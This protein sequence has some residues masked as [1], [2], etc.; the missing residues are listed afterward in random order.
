MT[1]SKILGT[2]GFATLLSRALALAKVE[3]PTLGGLEVRPDGSLRTFVEPGR[4]SGLVP[5]EDGDDVFLAQLLGLM[6]IFI[7][8]SLT[9]RLVQ[10]AWMDATLEGIET[11][12]GDMP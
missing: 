9:L 1:I 11:S 12:D 7:G 5:S 4:E 10:D 6:V 2:T 3:V 8:E